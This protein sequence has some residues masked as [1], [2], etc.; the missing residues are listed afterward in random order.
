MCFTIVGAELAGL[1]LAILLDRTGIPY[2][3]YERVAEVKPLG[4]E[5][6]DTRW[7]HQNNLF[8]ARL[9]VC[10]CQLAL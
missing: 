2:E 8:S 4:K 3:I 6:I 1:L 9:F 5:T 10:F 7:N